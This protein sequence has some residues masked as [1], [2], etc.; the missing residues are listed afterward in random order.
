M[1]RTENGSWGTEEAT[2]HFQYLRHDRS[3]ERPVL[4]FLHDALGSIAQW[5]DF[6]H[7]LARRTGLDA[8][9]Y[10]RRGHGQSAPLNGQREVD[11]LHYQALRTLPHLLRSLDISNP[12]LIGHSDGGTIALLHASEYP[13]GLIIAIA[14]HILVE[15]ITL[16]GIRQAV[17]QKENIVG[18]LQKYHGEKTT[19]LFEAW[20]DT[21]LNADFRKWNVTKE[22]KKIQC[23]VLA[24]QGTEDEYASEAQFIALTKTL[25]KKVSTLWIEN[26]GH[27]PHLTHTELLLDMIANFMD[28]RL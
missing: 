3:E 25:G 20:A 9:L 6:P 13:V 11:Y 8:L 23:P 26:T 7:L 28:S 18:R 10:E 5:R 2:L 16:S 15:P 4:I 12:I 1:L 19:A 14:A 22:V 24:I 21:W 17:A 27:F